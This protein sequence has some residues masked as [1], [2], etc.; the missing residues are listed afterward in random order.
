MAVCQNC[1]INEVPNIKYFCLECICIYE[2]CPYLKDNS[3]CCNKHCCD[4]SCVYEYN[5][6]EFH[7]LFIDDKLHS[8]PDLKYYE[9]YK[10]TKTCPSKFEISEC[11]RDWQNHSNFCLKNGFTDQRCRI[12]NTCR[13]IGCTQYIEKNSIYCSTHG[14]LCRKCKTEY[15]KTEYRNFCESCEKTLFKCCMCNKYYKNKYSINEYHRMCII[16]Y[17]IKRIKNSDLLED[18][19]SFVD[20]EIIYTNKNKDYRMI[21]LNL[22]YKNKIF[23]NRI[24]GEFIGLLNLPYDLIIMI[25]NKVDISK[26]LTLNY[27]LSR[28]TNAVDNGSV[29]S[30]KITK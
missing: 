23:P 11:N 3:K 10:K 28:N 8:F 16:C 7:H 14:I 6:E 26:A 4:S 21:V 9:L 30:I 12:L 13:E 17:D 22:Y 5:D 15:V 27:I 29:H 20:N 1:G 24:K 25:L 18:N 2:D 19:Y